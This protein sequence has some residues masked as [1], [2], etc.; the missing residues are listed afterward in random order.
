M[1]RSDRATN[2]QTCSI[3]KKPSFVLVNT[4][5]TKPCGFFFGDSSS[6]A[7]AA[8]SQQAT[9][10]HHLTHSQNYTTMLNADAPSGTQLNIHPTAWSGSSAD[11]G[12]ITFI[13][14]SGLATGG[15]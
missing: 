4:K 3:Q 5:L 13:Y 14:K 2:V 9:A 11:A 10:K 15:F 12:K 7:A 8:N 6:Y 1:S